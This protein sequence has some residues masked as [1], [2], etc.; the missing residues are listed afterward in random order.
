LLREVWRGEGGS[1]E[2]QKSER[3]DQKEKT[4][5]SKRAASLSSNNSKEKGDFYT[6][7]EIK[8]ARAVGQKGNQLSRFKRRRKAKD[9]TQGGE[10]RLTDV[11]QKNEGR[12]KLNGLED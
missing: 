9:V 5:I 7:G 11:T 12:G 6:K 10:K 3:T 8:E 2:G 4:P 1:R